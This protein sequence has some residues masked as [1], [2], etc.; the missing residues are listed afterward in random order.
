TD[1]ISY[2]YDAKGQ[3]VG[4]TDW[5]GNI[6]DFHYDEAGRHIATVRSNRLTTD[7]R[8]DPAGRLLRLRHLIGTK[9]RSQFAYAVDGRGNRTQAYEYL[10]QPST[11]VDTHD[12][13]DAAVSYPKGTWSDSGDFKQS[14]DTHARA[15]VEFTGNEAVLTF[16][17]G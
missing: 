10:A 2:L 3:L 7:Y 16:G 5:D 8:Y 11:V 17:V 4:M 12:K 14:T 9:V 15:E 13:D 1:S 6:A